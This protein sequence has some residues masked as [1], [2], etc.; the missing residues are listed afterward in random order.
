MVSIAWVLVHT[1]A[2][3]LCLNHRSHCMIIVIVY[4]SL[5]NSGCVFSPF[6]EACM[7]SIACMGVSAHARKNYPESG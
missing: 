1:R 7:V 3:P 6:E 4:T 5:V 2:L